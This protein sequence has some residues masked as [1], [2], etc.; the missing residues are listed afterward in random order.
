MKQQPCMQSIL[1]LSIC[2]SCLRC[3]ASCFHHER[4]LLDRRVNQSM[5]TA[6][7]DDEDDDDEDGDETDDTDED[8]DDDDEDD[9]D[10]DDDEDEEDGEE[11]GVA[12]R[13]IVTREADS[14]EGD[15]DIDDDDVAEELKYMK[16][17]DGMDRSSF[18]CVD[19]QADGL[20][21]GRGCPTPK[22]LFA[23]LNC[24]PGFWVSKSKLDQDLSDLRDMGIF[25]EVEVKVCR[26]MLVARFSIRSNI[27]SHERS[28]EAGANA[29]RTIEERFQE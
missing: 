8:D 12:S 10:E 27:K 6:A 26:R 11:E 28:F 15:S 4:A 3:L 1:P 24:Q 18:F 20:P 2:Y 17:P 5:A 19:V 13:S 14:S 23:S 21:V 7:D 9:D 16:P 25:K 29:D 22:E